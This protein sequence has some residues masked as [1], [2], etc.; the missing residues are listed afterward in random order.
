M[1]C[2]DLHIH[3]V[4]SDGTFTPEEIVSRARARGLGLISV[5]DHNVTEGTLETQKLAQAAGLGYITG[6]EID[7]LH[8]GTDV[9]ILCYGADLQNE[10]LL[11]CIRRAR[12]RLDDMSTELL[13][14]MLPDYPNLSMAEY[15]ALAHDPAQGGWKMLQYL[16][17]KHVTQTLREGFAFYDRYN[18]RYADA[19]FDAAADVIPLIHAAGGRAVLAHA[20]V[21]FEWNTLNELLAQTRDALDAGFDGAECYYPRHDAGVTRSLVALCRQRGLLIT[22]GSDCHGAFNHSEI[23]QT[24]T[25]IELLVIG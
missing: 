11:E 6:V 21:T 13:L 1:A 7:A 2:A 17:Q 5:C 18:V 12:S 20:G 9:H 25:P 10:A 4:C 24:R 19:G 14:R 16:R 3:S 22:A 15:G 23:G 8:R